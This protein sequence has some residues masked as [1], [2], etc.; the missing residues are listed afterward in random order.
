MVP[1]SLIFSGRSKIVDLHFSL[2]ELSS[3]LNSLF[4][5]L[6]LLLLLLICFS[7]AKSRASVSIQL[8]K[9]NKRKGDEV[10]CSAAAAVRCRLML[11]FGGR[12][13]ELKWIV[14]F[15]FGSIP[16]LPFLFSI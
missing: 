9:E 14:K 10:C 6:L 4:N 15:E 13:G 16:S 2:I 8:T 5:L 7:V 1:L 11:Q 3:D 12:R